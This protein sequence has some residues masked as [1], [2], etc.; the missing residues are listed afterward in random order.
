M[1]SEYASL[2]VRQNRRREI[3]IAAHVAVAPHHAEIVRLAPGAATRGGWFDAT[4]VD[5]SEGGLGFVSELFVPRGCSVQV[6]IRSPVQPDES[7]IIAQMRIKRV[8]MV[9]RRP[10]YL[11]GGVFEGN[12]ERF[13]EL[14]SRFLRSIDDIG[15]N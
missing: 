5:A 4:V 10:G 9:D 11:V 12:D 6:D 1:S 2:T 3:A 15:S 13:E 8:L 14:V 7:L